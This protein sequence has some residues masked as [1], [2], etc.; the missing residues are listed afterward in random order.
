MTRT[1]STWLTAFLL[2]LTAVPPGRAVDI[3]P[4]FKA[5]RWGETAERM[6]ALIK[7]SK[8]VILQRRTV[9]GREV[10]DVDGLKSQGQKKTV[11]Y[12][13]QGQ[14][15]EVEL[16]F[17]KDDWDETKY[18]TYMGE[19]RQKLEQF[20]GQGQLI[21]R[22]TEPAGDVTQTIVGWKW[23]QNNTA[24]ELIYFSA[25][26]AVHVFRTLSVHFKTY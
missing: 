22:K 4:P 9:E 7:G 24:A 11:F 23:S 19:W 12:F 16:Q 10:W 26:G 5:L 20:Y 2:T 25:Q 13:L 17:Q 1:I 18:N 21:S 14:L 15:V 8:A 6:E 3:Q